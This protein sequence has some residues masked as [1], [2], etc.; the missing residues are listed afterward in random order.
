MGLKLSC[1]AEDF[2]DQGTASLS[3]AN[4]R[5]KPS[6]H[7]SLKPQIR[8]CPRPH[9]IHCP[10]DTPLFAGQSPRSSGAAKDDGVRGVGKG[11]HASVQGGAKTD[12]GSGLRGLVGALQGNCRI[13]QYGFGH[14]AGFIRL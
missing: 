7:K 10:F 13:L 3:P 2:T 11:P 4:R 14:H 5:Q 1:I 6:A 9:P 12:V 8:A